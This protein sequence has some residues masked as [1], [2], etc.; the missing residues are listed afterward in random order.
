MRS[1]PGCAAGEAP[2]LV[3]GYGSSLRSDD[4]IGPW[5][6]TQVGRWDRADVRALALPQLVPELAEP[7]SGARAAIFV[8]AALDGE[9]SV[10]LRLASIEQAA[11]GRP[12][13]HTGGPAELLELALAVYGRSPPSWCL[14]IPVSD[15]GFGQR[16]SARAREAGMIA[17]GQIRALLADIRRRPCT[18]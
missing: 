15:L 14:S 16:L 5:F 6:A 11:S 2:V 8:D 12:L 3:I 17:L 18:R 9:S 4:A 10:L 7:L 1:P 13:G